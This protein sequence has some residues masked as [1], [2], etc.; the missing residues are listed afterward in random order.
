MEIISFRLH[1]E[2][3]NPMLIRF[4][5]CNI[6]NQ[7]SYK[8]WV[9]NENMMVRLYKTD[10]IHFRYTKFIH[11]K[12][13]NGEIMK[14]IFSFRDVE[15]YKWSADIDQTKLML[16][17]SSPITLMFYN[18]CNNVIVSYNTTG[19]FWLY[20]LSDD[21]ST[22]EI[23]FNNNDPIIKTANVICLSDDKSTLEIKFNNNDP[24]IKTANIICLSDDN[25]LTLARYD[26]H[27]INIHY[28]QLEQNGQSRLGRFIK[29]EKVQCEKAAIYNNGFMYSPKYNQILYSFQP[30]MD[31]LIKPA[32]R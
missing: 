28:Y 12:V 5:K 26:E 21:K 24:I 3:I 6:N 29:S 8:T 19:T 14:F 15:I 30:N 1:F 4:E 18:E 17:L 27:E 25:I 32:N 31:A 22:P 23:K 7:D 9:V 13:Q 11:I 10:N 2:S 16:L 20:G